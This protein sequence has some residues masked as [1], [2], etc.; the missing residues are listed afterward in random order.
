MK[1][2]PL[3]QK[4][5]FVLVVLT[6]VGLSWAAMLFMVIWFEPHHLIPITSEAWSISWRIAF[7]AVGIVAL[8]IFLWHGAKRIF[9]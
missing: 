8:V 9:T 4:T 6:I 1:N 3:T 7:F 5:L 2:L